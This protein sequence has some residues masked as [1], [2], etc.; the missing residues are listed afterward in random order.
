MQTRLYRSGQRVSQADVQALAEFLRTTNGGESHLHRLLEAHP[1]I[2]GA[3]GFLEFVSEFRLVK[4]PAAALRPGAPCFD[5]ADIVGAKLAVGASL[6]AKKLANVLELKGASAR[7]LD[8]GGRPSRDLSKAVHQLRDYA[9]WLSELPRN[10]EELARFGWE[11]W[12]PGKIVVIGTMAEFVDPGPLERLKQQLL[13]SDGIHLVLVDELLALVEVARV[14]SVEFDSLWSSW[15]GIVGMSPDMRFAAP[16]V[17]AQGGFAGFFVASLQLGQARTPY[18]N[19]DIRN[20]VPDGLRHIDMP[21]MQ[22]LARKLQIPF[23][24]ALIGFSKYRRWNKAEKSGIVVA[25]FDAQVLLSAA[26]AREDRNAPLRV[27]ARAR[28]LARRLQGPTLATRQEFAEA[29]REM[30][31]LL[32]EPSVLDTATRATM[33]GRVG[34]NPNLPL[35]EAV[36]LAVAAHAAYGHLGM[37]SKKA[38]DDA[39]DRVHEVL[40]QWGALTGPVRLRLT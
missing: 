6:T 4:G 9:A 33:P 16:M 39:R 31:P 25:S 40:R 15:E 23:A 7:V 36:F 24:D 13:E 14:R 2:M 29:I 17:L 21:R 27:P 18:G 3:L 32:D 37:T 19:V 12:N 5:R 1:A 34:T 30:F 11:V 28:R 26:Q 22:P 20:G 35:N 10:R 8:K 38:A